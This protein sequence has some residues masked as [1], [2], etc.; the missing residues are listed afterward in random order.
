MPQCC[1]LPHSIVSPQRDDATKYYI[2]F[3]NWYNLWKMG[4]AK[5]I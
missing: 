4:E 5:E 3:L 1:Q 2:N